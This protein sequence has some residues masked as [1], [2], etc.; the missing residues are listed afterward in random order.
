M[1]KHTIEIS[2]E[3]AHLSIRNRQLVLKRDGDIVGE[4]PCED[5]GVLLVDHPQTT[6][7]HSA[8]THLAQSNAA[9]VICGADHLPAAMVLPVSEH[10]QVVWRQ[11]D[12]IAAKRPLLKQLWKQIVV[13]K[14]QGQAANLPQ[15]TSTHR[16]LLAL[17]N[18]VRS[19]DPANV[20]ARAAKV[21]WAHWL[22][23]HEFR[24]DTN[25]DGINAFL[26]YGYA[27][28]RAA[29]GRAVV[30][31]GLL[32]SIGIHHCN[33]ANTFCLADDLVEPFR[34]LVD[35][36]VR[37]MVDLGYDDLN[38]PAKAQLLELLT[39]PMQLDDE[40]GPLM[41]ML[42]R[43]VASLVQCYAGES[44]TLRIPKAC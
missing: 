15:N 44:R 3:P 35:D 39:H 6:Y 25:G 17:S 34:P 23:E 1:I 28:V 36:Q 4:I 10:S 14:I 37:N 31:A 8:L 12:Q 33:R 5:I 7:T 24:R 19:G 11:N 26:N 32:P 27:I 30:S 41:V 20:E 13:A 38:Q 43:M 9:I 42:H 22:G 29:V 16:K 40:T 21:Y 18:E 2:R